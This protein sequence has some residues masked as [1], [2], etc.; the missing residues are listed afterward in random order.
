[1]RT[2]EIH[3]VKS[4]SGRATAFLV[5]VALCA[6][7]ACGGSGSSHASQTTSEPTTSSTAATTSTA[8]HTPTSKPAIGAAS[9]TCSRPHP[10]GQFSESFMFNGTRRTYQLCVPDRYDGTRPVPVVFEFHGFGS[11]AQQQVAYGDFRPLAD[12]DG[13]LIVAPDG[14]GN[15]KHF[16]LVPTGAGSDV[17]MSEALLDRVEATFCVDAERVYATGMSNGA[18]LTVVLACV[19]AD[20][21]AAFGPVAASGYRDGCGGA[22]PVSMV[23]F[24]GT[25]DPVV[26]FNG[27]KVNCCGGATVGA[28]PSNFAGWAQHDRCA[29]TFRD[30]QLGSQVTRRTWPGCEHGSDVVFYIVDGGGHTWPG[31]KI[32]VSR[33]GLTT[34]QVDASATIW[35][36]F[37]AHPL[38]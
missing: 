34:H 36:F 12:R 9:T 27:G 33:L 14:E 28:A 16:S 1:V 35:D 2:V 4:H 18:G 17:A 19:A 31:S 7:A 23:G 8:K 24:A 30:E 37:V 6:F 32:D 22:R 5:V 26:P 29:T 20:R 21:F 10:A 3:A 11:N 25:A 13:F 38:A 15:P